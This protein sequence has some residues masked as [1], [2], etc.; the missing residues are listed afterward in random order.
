MAGYSG[1]PLAR[2]LGIKEGSRVLLSG[3]PAGFELDELPGGATQ[4]RRAGAG[5]YDVILGFCPD[6]ATLIGKFAGWR[7]RLAID[8]GLWIAWPKKSG[9]MSTDLDDTVV[10]EYGL[11]QGLVDN[12]VAAIDATWSGLRFVV[13]LADR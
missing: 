4:T 2:K 13:R 12:K 5:P 3:A 10:R 1:T 7:A 9:G 8:G 11:A 6:Q